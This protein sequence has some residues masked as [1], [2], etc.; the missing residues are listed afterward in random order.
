MN[1]KLVIIS[2]LEQYEGIY[3]VLNQYSV[4]SI[5]FDGLNE[6]TAERIKK[7]RPTPSHFIIFARPSEMAVLFENVSK[8]RW[9]FPFFEKLRVIHSVENWRFNRLMGRS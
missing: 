2:F 1:E 6:T 9:F 5:T 4:R 3:E 8:I 7:L